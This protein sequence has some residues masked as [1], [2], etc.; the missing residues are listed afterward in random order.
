MPELPLRSATRNTRAASSA[1]I[2]RVRH[3]ERTAACGTGVATV[4]TRILEGWERPAS[5]IE[6]VGKHHP[7]KAPRAGGAYGRRPLWQTLDPHNERRHRPGWFPRQRR[8]RP[9]AGRGGLSRPAPRGQALAV[10]AGRAAPRGVARAG[11]VSRTG[12]GDR[13]P[14][15]ARAAR[16]ADRAL[17]ALPPAG[18]LRA[19]QPE[20]AVHRAEATLVPAAPQGRG[21][22]RFCPHQRAGV[23]PVA[24]GAVLGTGAR[25]HLLQAP[26]VRARAHRA[27]RACLS[28]RQAAAVS[29]VVVRVR[30]AAEG[31]RR[32]GARLTAAPWVRSRPCSANTTAPRRWCAPARR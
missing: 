21:E 12:R 13:R 16:R 25:G 22:L 23:R 29:G 31:R 27:R 28:A 14:G 1:R 20:A 2:T 7:R 8:H 18:A 6:I 30:R 4:P 19:A 10:P 17:A 11:A 26:G 15:V 32:R 24:L 9:D 3:G 5:L